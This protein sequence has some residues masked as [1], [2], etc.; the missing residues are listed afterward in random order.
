M[1]LSVC[2]PVYGVERYIERCARSLFSQT[3]TD[4]VEFIFVDD[5]SPDGSIARLERV[6]QDFPERRDFVRIV[7]HPV[8][9]GLSASRETAFDMAQGEYVTYCDSDDW[10]EPGMYADMLSMA[11][12]TGADLVFEDIL[13][14]RDGRSE[15][16]SQCCE[17]TPTGLVSA[18]LN[19]SVGG[20]LCNKL[21]RKETVRRS[22]AR[23]R[24]GLTGNEDVCYLCEFLSSD[25]KVVY[26]AQAHYHYEQRDGSLVHL[27]FRRH[28]ESMRKIAKILDDCLPQECRGA[29]RI[30]KERVRYEAVMCP[31]MS[32]EDLD[33]FL[34]EVVRLCAYHPCYAKRVLFWLAMHG[35][36]AILVRG[37]AV[38]YVRLKGLLARC[39]K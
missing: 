2:I 1:K 38:I 19:G 29:F 21:F 39:R 36:R 13:V 15:R 3:L 25:C 37:K 12:K 17:Q 31:D 7:R 32:T 9:R 6:L 18:I 27:G 34:P 20:F 14:D 35:F 8:N 4:G 30:W 23:H 11:E 24:P 16:V 33:T 5:C 22:R 26:L 28:L 10:V